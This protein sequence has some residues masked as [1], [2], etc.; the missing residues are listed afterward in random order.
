VTPGFAVLNVG[1]VAEAA[2]WTLIPAI[3]SGRLT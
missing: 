1:S 2:S 3:T